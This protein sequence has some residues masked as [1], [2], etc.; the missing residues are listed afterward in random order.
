MRIGLK[1]WLRWAAL[2]AV[3]A[4]LT[5]W[6]WWNLPRTPEELYRKRCSSCHELARIDGYGGEDMRAIVT[7][8]RERNGAAAV[9]DDREAEIIIRYLEESRP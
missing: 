9:I 6:W 5:G 8:M 4:V 1:C 3:L 2:L 7:T